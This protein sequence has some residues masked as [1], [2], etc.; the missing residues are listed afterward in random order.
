MPSLVNNRPQKRRV[1]GAGK[2][3]KGPLARPVSMPNMMKAPGSS[4]SY[5]NQRDGKISSMKKNSDQQKQMLGMALQRKR[6]QAGKLRTM[7]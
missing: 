5:K 7:R 1:T 6:M 4:A 2:N 3:V